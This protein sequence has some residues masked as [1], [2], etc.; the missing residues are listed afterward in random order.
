MQCA[1]IGTAGDGNRFY[2]DSIVLKGVVGSVKLKVEP[3]PGRL[4]T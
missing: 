1:S 3:A 2:V 4:S